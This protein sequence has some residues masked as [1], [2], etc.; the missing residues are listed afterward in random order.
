MLAERDIPE[1]IISDRD[2][3]FT[4]HF[5][6]SLWPE[7]NTKLK[8]ST[9]FHPQTDGLT[10]R[11]N[12]TVV[13]MLRSFVDADQRNWDSLLPWMQIANNDAVCQSTGKTPFEM[14]NGRTRR[15]LLDVE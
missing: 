12:R 13:E 1:Y 2:S 14:N 5:W 7:W 11:A 8:L 3:K 10:E 9:A 4:S 6:Q 15:T